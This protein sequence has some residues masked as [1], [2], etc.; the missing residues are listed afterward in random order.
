MEKLTHVIR[1]LIAPFQYWLIDPLAEAVDRA[2]HHPV[3]WAA[4]GVVGALALIVLVMAA[5]P[6]LRGFRRQPTPVV[7]WV[8]DTRTDEKRL[9]S[10]RDEKLR[11]LQELGI[12]VN[13]HR[14]EQTDAERAISERRL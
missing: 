11:E 4:A 1:G 7:P 10:Y 8:P 2:L 5:T 14:R 13:L 9:E 12:Q 3:V 6:W